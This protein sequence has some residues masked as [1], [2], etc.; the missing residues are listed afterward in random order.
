MWLASAGDAI[1]KG[2]NY[3]F[4]YSGTAPDLGCFETNHV[5]LPTQLLSFH[6]V[7]QQVDVFL[8]WQVTNQ[9]QIAGWDIKR[10]DPRGTYSWKR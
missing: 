2:I 8:N 1:D 10:T 4:P 7:D 9:V 5:V 6:A 3:R